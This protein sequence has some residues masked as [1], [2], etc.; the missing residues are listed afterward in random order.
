MKEKDEISQ[1]SE[2]KKTMQEKYFCNLQMV[3]A[4]NAMWIV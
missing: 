1:P 4:S 2:K 3:G